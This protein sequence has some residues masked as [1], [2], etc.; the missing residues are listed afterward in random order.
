MF[1]KAMI[2]YEIVV[3]EKQKRQ[4]H[5]QLSQEDRQDLIRQA[6]SGIT[7]QR[8]DEV[9][10]RMQGAQ[11]VAAAY[12]DKYSHYYKR[13][14]FSVERLLETPSKIAQALR[15]LSQVEIVQASIANYI[16]SQ[17]Y[18]FNKFMSRAPYFTEIAAPK[19]VERYE[20][21]AALRQ[22]YRIQPHTL[23]VSAVRPGLFDTVKR[24]E[25]H[26]KFEEKV[27]QRMIIQWGSEEEVW[28]M[29]GQPGEEEVFSDS[30]KETRSIWKSMFGE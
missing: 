29:C 14:P 1:G 12:I 11:A 28:Q 2:P 25:E 26:F 20:R 27:L 23:H 6:K 3:R 19:S 17:F 10:S 5:G 16:E 4:L 13:H 24:D 8:P 7:V 15:V 22:E 21:W 18:W 30:F 9:V